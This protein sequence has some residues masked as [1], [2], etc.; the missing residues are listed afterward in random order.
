VS[1]TGRSLS[2]L[3]NSMPSLTGLAPAVQICR[4]RLSNPSKSKRGGYKAGP[5]RRDQAQPPAGHR[6]AGSDEFVIT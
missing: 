6:G 4:K 2:L 5:H 1:A 3:A